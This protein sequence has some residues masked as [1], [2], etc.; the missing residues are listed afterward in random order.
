MANNILN[1]TQKYETV[2]DK[3]NL[4]ESSSGDYVKL[5]FTKDGHIISHG[6]D[7]IPWG[8]NGII[9]INR[10]PV[11]STKTDTS[12]LWDSKTIQDKINASFTAQDAM[13]FKGTISLSNNQYLVN[14]TAN[15]TINQTALQGDTYRVVSAG[16]YFGQK[17]EVGDLVICITDGST[18]KD[19]TWTV[20]QTNIN[21]QIEHT[22][23][24]VARHFY[25]NDTDKFTIYAPTS[26]GA[27]GQLLISN[28]TN[29]APV[30]E[31][32]SS[33]TVGTASKVSYA[34]SAGTGLSFGSNVTYNGSAARTLSLVAAT[35][36]TLGG[37]IVGNNITLTNGIISITRENVVSALGG[38]ILDLIKVVS[39]DANGLAPRL[40]TTNT[41]TISNS[42]YLLA[43]NDGKT[44]PSW[45]KLPATAFSNTWRDIKIGGKSIG[46]KNLNFVPTGDIYVYSTDQNTS[47]T[48]IFDIGFGI[49]WYNIDTGEYET[50]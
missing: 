17:C 38:E 30:W 23:N 42:F 6:T 36:S 13:R 16:T 21:G 18:T 12:H 19:A 49:S 43:S 33:I 3:L 15:T 28:G 25:S 22:I 44:E 29:V 2:K 8:A 7:Y 26:S 1:F 4:T 10:L 24:G 39:K 31:N 34:L 45:Y 37:V 35:T 5:Y 9:P 48:D 40:I 50:A 32:P 47:T 41:A 27:K 46:N 11:D 20:A 14:G